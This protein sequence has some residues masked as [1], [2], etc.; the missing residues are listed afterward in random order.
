[1]CATSVGT[2]AIR[3][4]GLWC[5]AFARN[6]HTS[7]CLRCVFGARKI[8]AL[9]GRSVRGC[10]PFVPVDHFGSGSGSFHAGFSVTACRSKG[11]GH[12][13]ADGCNPGNTT[14]QTNNNSSRSVSS[15]TP[16]ATT[17]SSTRPATTTTNKYAHLPIFQHAR[18]NHRTPPRRRHQ[19]LPLG[20][21]P[22]RQRSASI[23]LL[24]ASPS[25]LLVA[26]RRQS[27]HTP[28]GVSAL[29]SVERGPAMIPPG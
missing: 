16:A 26:A 4:G 7:S 10:S 3:D 21:V 23:V 17:S 8:A 5:G 20:D 18:Y 9:G 29:H 2:R 14:P 11:V 22:L 25:I 12:K 1:M 13:N 24:Q 28:G 27:S 15:P 19:S 6:V